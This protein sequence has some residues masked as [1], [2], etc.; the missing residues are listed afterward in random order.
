[1]K[2]VLLSAMGCGDCGTYNVY[3]SLQSGTLNSTVQHDN[4]D[5]IWH[6]ASKPLRYLYHYMVR[7]LW[8]S[9]VSV[10]FSCVSLSV[11][12]KLTTCPFT[13]S[14]LMNFCWSYFDIITTRND[15]D[16]E[17][18]LTLTRRYYTLQFGVIIQFNSLFI[19]VV[20][21]KSKGQ[22]WSRHEQTEET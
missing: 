20:T 1:M 11:E 5:M 4:G 16:R 21:Q 10:Y 8:P 17:T 9:N 12:W 13:F 22:L 6:L 3:R 18:G 14:W 2:G 7:V 15:D 19:Y